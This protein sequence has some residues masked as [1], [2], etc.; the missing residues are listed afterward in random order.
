M[1]ANLEITI[2]L[3]S[4]WPTREELSARN[5]VEDA[6]RAADIGICVGAGGGMGV[7]DLGFR[8][9][10]EAKLADAKAAIEGIMKSLMPGFEYRVRVC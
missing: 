8:V 3:A 7:M 1:G 4:K 2:P 9:D 10:D 6:L 5:A